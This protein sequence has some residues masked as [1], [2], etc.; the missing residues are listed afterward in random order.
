MAI[1]PIKARSPLY[2]RLRATPTRWGRDH[3]SKLGPR[4]LNFHPCW[5]PLPPAAGLCFQ[6]ELALEP[7]L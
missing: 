7:V 5:L 6:C 3:L 2:L 1:D 4:D